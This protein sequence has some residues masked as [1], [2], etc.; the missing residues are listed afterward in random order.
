[1]RIEV[2]KLDER[3]REIEHVY[4]LSEFS[5]EDEDARL[6]SDVRVTAHAVRRRGEVTLSGSIDTAVE[7]RCD[8][9]L[10]PVAQPV[11]IDFKADLATRG[12][13]SESHEATGLQDAD[14]DFS[15]FEGEAINLDEIVRE[16]IL[17]ALPAR[18]LCS[19]ECKGLCP[20]C[21][22]NRNEQSC[23][24]AT[25]EIDPRWSALAELKDR[26]P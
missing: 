5:L 6:A 9:C 17:L 16:Q 22:A 1:M 3:G 11:K 24:C 13:G 23:D 8:R 21:G 19:D 25:E 4:P 14:M 15:L 7:L 12:E 18:H 10:A 20:A 2:E 26:K